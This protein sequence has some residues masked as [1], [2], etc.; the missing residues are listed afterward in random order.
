[1]VI[2]FVAG[3]ITRDVLMQR[4]FQLDNDF[5]L[6]GSDFQTAVKQLITAQR[7]KCSGKFPGVKIDCG[8]ALFELVEFFKNGD[9]HHNVM[10]LKLIDAGA[11]MQYYIRIKNEYFLFSLS[12]VLLYIMVRKEP[13][14]SCCF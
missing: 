14:G 2:R 1:M 7:I 5:A 12:H 8:P 6:P 10:L 9:G 4:L 13:E 11:V 3:I